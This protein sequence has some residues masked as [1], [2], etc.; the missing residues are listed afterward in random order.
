MCKSLVAELHSSLLTLVSQSGRKI[1]SLIKPY[2]YKYEKGRIALFQGAA[3]PTNGNAA[4]A[5]KKDDAATN[6]DSDKR[7]KGKKGQANGKAKKAVSPAT[8]G[9]SPA[10][11]RKTAVKKDEDAKQE[12]EAE[13]NE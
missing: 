10:K 2:G 4:A 8:D 1:D 13:Q 11:K 7:P 12:D 9:G 3:P 6:G 5:V